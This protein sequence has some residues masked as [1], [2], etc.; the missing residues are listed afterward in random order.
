M[1]GVERVPSHHCRVEKSKIAIGF[2][3]LAISFMSVRQLLYS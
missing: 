3:H 1:K 2:W